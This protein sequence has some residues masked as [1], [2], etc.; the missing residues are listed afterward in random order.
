MFIAALFIISWIW[1]Q[2][3]YPS[4][5]EWIK[6]LWYIYAIE[7]LVQFQFSHSV[8]SDSLRP[9]ELQHARLP[10]PLPTP[11][12]HPNPCPSSRWCHPTIS[13][14]RVG[15]AIPPSHPLSSASP[16]ALNLS[17]HQ[18]L[19][20]SY[21]LFSSTSS[22]VGKPFSACTWLWCPPHFNI[23]VL[24]SSSH[25][26]HGFATK[27]QITHYFQSPSHLNFLYLTTYLISPSDVTSEP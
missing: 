11:G 15:D 22:C 17:Q 20:Q 27:I 5:D 2:P 18:G 14:H 25:H 13:S 16:P 9:H 19:F 8:M 7:Y 24:P 23:S 4:T 26:T 3:R 21:S 10:C 6:K 12:V 1:K